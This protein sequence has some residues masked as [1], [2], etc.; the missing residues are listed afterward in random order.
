MSATVDAI[1]RLA[2][3]DAS[4][5]EADL[6]ADVY[7][8]LTSGELALDSGQVARLEVPTGDG[9]RRRLDVEIG[10]CVIEVKKDLRVAGILREAEQQLAGYVE[11]QHRRLG[12]RYVGILTDGT[13]WY[14]YHHNLGVLHRVAELS[15]NPSAPDEERLIVWLEAILAT[16]DSIK[17]NPQEI[18][19]RFGADSPAHTLDHATLKALYEAAASIPEVQLKRDLWAKLLRTAFGKAFTDNEDLFINHT[20]LVL[21]AE[22]IGH[23]VV[24]F[25]IART[26]ELTPASLVQGTAFSSAQ[27]HG[28]IE[29][30]FFDWVLHAPG[31]PEFIAELADRIARFDWNHVEHDVLKILYES[32]I[33][34]TERASLGEYYTPDWLADRVVSNAVDSPLSQRALDPS[35]GSGTFI[36]H[37]V[38]AYLKSADAAGIPNGQ[39]V[40]G[41]TEHVFGMDIHPVAVT[42]ARITYLLAIGQ[43]RLA[44]ADRGAIGIPVY[45][46][47]ALQWEQRRDLLNSADVVTISTAG[48]DLVEGGGAIFGDDL[49]FPHRILHDAGDFDRL[50]SAMADKAMDTSPKSSRDL[51]APTLR[52]F[53]VHADDVDQVTETFDTMRRLHASGRDHIW[54]YYV[55]NLIRPIW[56]SEADQKVDVLIGNPPWLRYSKMTRPMQDRYKALARD[57]GLLSG[58]L[59]ASGRD[60][61]T[62]FVTRSVELYLKPSGRF[63]FVMP[64]GTLTRKPHE[65]FRSGRWHSAS[66]AH[67]S[68]A[69]EKPWDLSKAPTGFPMV[70]CVIH[71]TATN[72]TASS[73]PTQTI[74]WAAKLPSPNVTWEV[75]EPK[76]TISEGSVTALDSSNLEASPY[77][78]RFRQG[79]VLAPRALLFMQEVP[80]GPL[81][82]GAGRLAVQSRRTTSEK[83]PW[84]NV[85]SLRGTVERV[86]AR[87]IHLGETLLPFRMLP[88]LRAVLPITD[89]E[90]LTQE[91]IENYVGLSQWWAQAEDTWNKHKSK[92]DSSALLD[93]ID[94]HGQLSAQLP[95]ARHRVLYTASGNTLAA[96]RIESPQ[97]IIE[98]KLYWAAASSVD[99]A[100][101]LTGILNSSA[102]LERVKPLQA[103]GLFGTRDF[104]KT[105]FS[106]PIPTFDHRNADHEELVSHVTEAEELASGVDITS[107]GDF[108]KLRRI[109]REELAGNGLTDRIEEVVGRIV[110]F[111]V[112]PGETG[113]GA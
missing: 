4:R 96:A 60:L 15:L 112:L 73:M 76:F 24:G 8:L 25:D 84:K 35:C 98:H 77:K 43:D 101:Y 7:L 97:C 85:E 48:D 55:R 11:T 53:G 16:Q 79:A 109:I 19:R 56:L 81:G 64:Y 67:L 104:D 93:R 2:S 94:Y 70:S 103:L 22:I 14:L 12:T 46:G 72:G 10:H 86:F 36:F 17:P 9:T 66:I 65:G 49:V 27:I 40:A 37:A 108:K 54:G 63:S 57:R 45:L 21:T 95:S 106:L 111:P 83:Q 33:T 29:S 23:A 38:R 42:L 28:V 3:R 6:Q 61:S 5:T 69:F 30:D 51:I 90:I 50:V 58:P 89:T 47:D 20:L 78:K 18:Q 26:G 39:A 113:D 31:G 91:Q 34:S 59:G 52:Q 105:V 62:L 82:A 68:V 99:E 44:A 110:P 102:V 100:R 80:A 74:S 107:S 32:V 92:A 1:R 13:E 88:P 71:G 41:V 87:E 75:A